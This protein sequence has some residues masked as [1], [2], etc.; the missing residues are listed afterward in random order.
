MGISSGPRVSVCGAVAWERR[1]RLIE[2][3]TS[4]PLGGAFCTVS[5]A[6][7]KLARWRIVCMPKP[8]EDVSA[9][10]P[11]PEICTTNSS[12]GRFDSAGFR[13]GRA[14][15]FEGVV[16]GPARCD[17]DAWRWFDPGS[18]TAES[19]ANVQL[20]LRSRVTRSAKFCSAVINPSGSAARDKAAASSR[21]CSSVSTMSA[22]TCPAR[23]CSTASRF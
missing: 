5:C 13:C 8:A 7:I 3:C 12:D 17:T 14:A 15:V 16:H 22:C 9:T 21:V 6:P 19:T 23:V 2:Q 18:N 4:A 1:V 20:I 10:K 11:F